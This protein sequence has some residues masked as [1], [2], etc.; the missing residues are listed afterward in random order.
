MTRD[1]LELLTVGELA[2][3]WRISKRTIQR[4]ITSGEIPAVKIGGQT[5]I[6]RDVAAQI[7]RGEPVSTISVLPQHQNGGAR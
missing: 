2:E 7:A 1:E 4:R 6:R 5:R 3:L